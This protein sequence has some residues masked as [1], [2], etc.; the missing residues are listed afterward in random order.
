MFR[1]LKTTRIRRSHERTVRPAPP[2]IGGS[3]PGNAIWLM[4]L[5]PR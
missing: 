1:R 2:M 5:P 3:P 4:G